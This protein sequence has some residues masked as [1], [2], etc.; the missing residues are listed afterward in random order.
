LNKAVLDHSLTALA[1]TFADALEATTTD[2]AALLARVPAHLR[3]ELEGLLAL[4]P[5][6]AAFMEHARWDDG[7]EDQPSLPTG[8][9]IARYTIV[10]LIGRGGMGIVYRAR[11][12]DPAREVALKLIRPG[13]V[14]PQMVRRLRRET[15][16][17]GRL[18][19]PAIA[20]V[21]DAGVHRDGPDEQPWL[22]MELVEGRPISEHAADLTRKHRLELLA[23][24]CDAVAHAHQRGVIHLDLKP[25]NILVDASGFAKVLDFGVSRLTDPDAG[26]SI[27]PDDAAGTPAYM[28]PEQLG[29]I[30][31]GSETRSDIYGLGVIAYEMLT[32]RHPFEPRPENVPD[33]IAALQTRRPA[34]PSS[35]DRALRGDLG[36]VLLRA[37]APEPGARYQSAAELARDLRAVAAGEPI[38][39]TQGRSAIAALR[40]FARRYRGLTAAIAGALAM[41]CIGVGTTGWQAVRATRAE[42]RAERRAGDL[43]RVARGLLNANTRSKHVIGSLAARRAWIGASVPALRA[44][45]ADAGADPTRTMELADGWIALAQVQAGVIG[46]GDDDLSGAESSYGEAISILESLAASPAP[47]PSVRPALARARYELAHVQMATGRSDLG[48]STIAQAA[49]ELERLVLADPHSLELRRELCEYYELRARVAPDKANARVTAEQARAFLGRLRPVTPVGIAAERIAAGTLMSLARLELDAGE[50]DEAIAG[51]ARVRAALAPLVAA[52]PGDIHTRLDIADTWRLQADA[53]VGRADAAGE[54]DALAQA[55]TLYRAI[56]ADAPDVVDAADVLAMVLVQQATCL[57]DSPGPRRAAP[58]PVALADEAVSL[59]ESLVRADPGSDQARLRL[60]E[61]LAASVHALTRA[62]SP[63]PSA[64]APARAR[65]ERARAIIDEMAAAHPLSQE[66]LAVRAEIAVALAPGGASADTLRS[67]GR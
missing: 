63:P 8:T 45:A 28:S 64:L 60:A 10:E 5:A 62:Q 56:H 23:Q 6:A 47:D 57:S 40:L 43:S 17:Q 3:A 66:W 27:A 13:R 42:A 2:R 14:S 33:A 21:Y 52:A 4:S 61:A 41:L 11:Q 9:R 65:A 59:A 48:Q 67:T 18:L 29:L 15:G 55:A 20:Q 12:D 1:E 51:F 58:D 25:A 46:V 32:G 53:S 16:M 54:Q 30:A 22:V 36:A 44:L 35:L 7:P 38:A 24:V 26:D 49:A 37:I 39:A 19:H 31:G 50:Y 34:S